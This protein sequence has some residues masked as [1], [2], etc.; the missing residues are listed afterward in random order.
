MITSEYSFFGACGS[1][2]SHFLCFFFNQVVAE[3][4]DMGEA[5][6]PTDGKPQTEIVL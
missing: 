6:S 5:E 1:S 3:T 4:V 2:V